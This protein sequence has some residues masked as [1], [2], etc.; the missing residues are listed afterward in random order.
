MS[1]FYWKRRSL[2]KG[3]AILALILMPLAGCKKGGPSN[4]SLAQ[5]C[6]ESHQCRSGICLFQTPASEDGLCTKPCISGKECP[7]GWSCTAVTQ[8]GVIVCQQGNS[9]P[10]GF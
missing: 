6:T 5:P 8:D 2:W 10:F 1:L 7:E 3:A 4:L 9:T